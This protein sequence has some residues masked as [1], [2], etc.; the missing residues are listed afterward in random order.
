MLRTF[1]K[2]FIN[3]L[4]FKEYCRK[5]GISTFHKFVKKSLSSCPTEPT[6]KTE[7]QLLHLLHKMI[8]NKK[9]I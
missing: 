7:F 5:T 2:F 9:V 1:S 6:D 8:H 4:F 3:K